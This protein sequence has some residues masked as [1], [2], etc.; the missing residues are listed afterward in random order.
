MS[1]SELTS[2]AREL[3]Q[4]VDNYFTS[5]YVIIYERY[6]FALP[7]ATQNGY[8]GEAQTSWPEHLLRTVRSEL[9]LLL[10]HRDEL[11]VDSDQCPGFR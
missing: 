2:Y 11:G 4:I 1:G 6:S 10:L 7:F 8:T 3:S 9:G 5:V